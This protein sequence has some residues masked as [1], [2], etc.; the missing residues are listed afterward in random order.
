[1]NEIENSEFLSNLDGIVN[2]HCS[3][4][5][6]RLSEDYP[7]HI[8]SFTINQED[9]SDIHAEGASRRISLEDGRAG[10]GFDAIEP[11]KN[12]PQQTPHTDHAECDGLDSQAF[13]HE[14]QDFVDPRAYQSCDGN[15]NLRW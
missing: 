11:E 7:E 15:W 6:K 2:Q 9:D 8:L 14:I 12:R 5:F 4:W 13:H 3:D 1:M 10:L